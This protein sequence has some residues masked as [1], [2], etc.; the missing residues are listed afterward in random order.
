MKRHVCLFI[1]TISVIIVFGQTSYTCPDCS[2]RG[3][4]VERCSCHN[5]A[6]YCMTCDY[7]GVVEKQCYSC[8]GSGTKTTT[9]NKA[10]D[11]CGGARYAKM[12]KQTPCSCRGGKRPTTRYGTTVYVDCTRCS[13]K[14][15]LISYYNAACRYCGGRGYSGT[16]NI[17]IQCDACSGNGKSISTCSV[18]EGKGC[19]PCSK[20]GGYG[21]LTI[22]CRRCNG[23]GSIYSQY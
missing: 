15:Y 23:N 3:K 9:K 16:E 2:G 17:T 14:G 8:Y 11:Q 20:C 7:K 22:T 19:Y 10:C 1:F 18:C 12:E 6:I 5:G 4:S 13:G 21:N